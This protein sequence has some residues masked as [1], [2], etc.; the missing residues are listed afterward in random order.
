MNTI[1][2]KSLFPGFYKFG[3]LTNLTLGTYQLQMAKSFTEEHF[4]SEG[5]FKVLNSTEDQFLLSSKIQS[6]HI[7]SKCYQ[8]WISLIS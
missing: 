2:I 1:I 8:L 7:S 3:L 6:R 5:K 4:D